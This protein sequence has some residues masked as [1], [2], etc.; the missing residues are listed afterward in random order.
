MAR[1]PGTPPNPRDASDIPLRREAV[2][3]A[4][5]ALGEHLFE[6]PL[7]PSPALSELTGARVLLKAEN[8]Q[9]AGSFKV[10]GSVNK[11][12]KL[13][14]AGPVREVV[15]ASAGNHAQGVAYA[16]SRFGVPATVFMPVDA[17]VAKRRATERLGAGVVLEGRNYDES[18]AAA[19]AHAEARG[20]VFLDGFDDWDVIEG[21]ATLG[22]E[23]VEA[24]HG[25]APDLVLVPAGG[26][27][28]LAG[29]LFYLR[30]ALGDRVRVVGLQSERAPALAES[31][32]R[33]REGDREGLPLQT[34]T[35]PTIADGVRIGRPG[36]RPWRVIA[37]WADDVRTVGERPIYEAIVHLYEHARLVVEGAGALGVA[38]LLDGVLRPEPGAT[39]VVVVS[40]GNVDAAAMEKIIHAYLYKTGRRA[41]FRIQV[42][43]VPGELVRVLRI[44]ER[45]R[46]NVAEIH[47][48]PILAR[49]VSPEYTI[50]DL[51]VETEG[52]WQVAEIARVLE[53]ERERIRAAGDEP[54][55]VLERR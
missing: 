22:A 21:Q 52:E 23:I 35:T 24:L 36:D 15:A 19:L 13:V 9:R 33:W 37:R 4:R 1:D 44:F 39:V 38:A 28:L 31:F 5:A 17:P 47:Q 8:V 55:E 34:P 16:A 18:R 48:R 6:T 46:L 40:G 10:R 20:A 43:D 51:C 54:F 32:R 2:D 12:R 14:A 11:I 29:V 7:L 53:E 45:E 25:A 3:E 49:P 42:K 41:V 50:F 27:G 26:G 30:A